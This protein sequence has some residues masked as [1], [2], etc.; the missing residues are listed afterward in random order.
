MKFFE[1]DWPPT[2]SLKYFR[3]RVAR[4]CRDNDERV[5]TYAL[6]ILKGPTRGCGAR[7]VIIVFK[8]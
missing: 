1:K 3:D 6:D 4:A 7:V 8:M 5:T 2:I